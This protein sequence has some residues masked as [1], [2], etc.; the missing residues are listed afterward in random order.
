[1][2]LMQWLTTRTV[3]VSCLFTNFVPMDVSGFQNRQKLR[4]FDIQGRLYYAMARCG[5]RYEGLERFVILMNHPSPMME[6]HLSPTVEN[7][8]LLLWRTIVSYDGEPSSPMM[9]NHPSPMMEN[10]PSPMME[11]HPSPMM[12]NHPSPMMENHPS[13]MME[14]HPS[15]MMENHP[16][17]M[18]ENHPSPMMEN[19]PS[20][21]MENHPSPMMEKN[22]RKMCLISISIS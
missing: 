1:M 4:S 19:H 13:P 17:P 15:P 14:N 2:C 8:R 20:P 3:V 16:S 5:D 7:H 22:H 6:N 9:E 12:E 21:M 18:M 10:H 11:N